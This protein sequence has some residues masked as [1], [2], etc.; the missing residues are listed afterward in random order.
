MTSMTSTTGRT[1]LR[2]T[3]EGG[4]RGVNIWAHARLDAALRFVDADPMF[5]RVL[6]EGVAGR[7]LGSVLH[8]GFA[9]SLRA[10]LTEL[11]AGQV[12]R[13]TCHT[14]LRRDDA[15]VIAE[16]TAVSVTPL[17]GPACVALAVRQEDVRR[18][19]GPPSRQ[20]RLSELSARILEHV[21]AG[22]SSAQL[23]RTLFLSK[24]GVDYHV[25]SLVRKLGAPNRT[26]MV[27]MAYA[28]GVL[29]AAQWPPKVDPALIG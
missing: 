19:S 25:T 18:T 22:M 24:Q 5:R 8:P 27:S 29:L 10:R 6:G 14:V 23:A 20:V 2:S 3:V 28:T 7:C 16:V 11:V 12:N 4:P 13:V 21:A 9:E 26:G 17:R 1:T 15:P